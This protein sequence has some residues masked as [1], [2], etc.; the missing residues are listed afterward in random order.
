MAPSAL[1]TPARVTNSSR[2]SVGVAWGLRWRLGAP[3]H[4]ALRATPGSSPGGRLFSREAG[5]DRH[6]NPLARSA[7]P[8]SSSTAGSSIVAGIAQGSWSAI[9]FSVPRRI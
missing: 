1:K 4:P 5:E 2:L 7:A 9:F 8:I 3:P 6:Q